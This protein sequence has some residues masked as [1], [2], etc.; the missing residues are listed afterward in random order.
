VPTEYTINYQIKDKLASIDL[1]RCH[2]D[3]LFYVFYMYCGDLMQ[4]QASAML[5]DRDWRFHKEKRIWITKV[6]GVEAHHKTPTF[7][8][9]FYLYFDV[10]QWKKVQ[11]EMTIEYNKL[12][13][14]PQIPTQ[15]QYHTQPSQLHHTGGGVGGGGGGGGGGTSGI[16]GFASAPNLSANATLTSSNL[17]SLVSNNTANN[18]STPSF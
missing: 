6:P 4:M 13:E 8:K 3:T 11:A 18:T 16:V 12:A 17:A 10:Q 7:E 9:G 15:Q 14:K 2:E 1:I 5:Y